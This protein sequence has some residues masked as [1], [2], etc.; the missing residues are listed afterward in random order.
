MSLNG[1]EW[2]SKKITLNIQDIKKGD[3]VWM[4]IDPLTEN[5][6]YCV[7]NNINAMFIEE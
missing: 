1:T 7:M 5:G 3:A 6:I 2:T 4:R